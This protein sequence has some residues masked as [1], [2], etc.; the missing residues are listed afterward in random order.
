MTVHFDCTMC[1]KCCHDLKLPLSVD[2]ALVWAEKGHPIKLLVEA[3]PWTGPPAENDGKAIHDYGRTFPEMC[4]DIPIRVAV[5]LV[6]WHQGACPYL[7]PDMRC[8]QYAVRP[9]VCRIYPLMARPF[10]TL[11]PAKRL[12][13]PEAWSADLPVLMINGEATD[14]QSAQTLAD[15]RHAMIADVPRL[16]ALCSLLGWSRAGFANE[17]FAVMTLDPA[18]LAKALRCAGENRA[19]MSGMRNWTYVTNRQSTLAMLQAAD[20]DAQLVSQDDGYLGSFPPER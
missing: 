7:L 18:R 2:E 14:P 10:E 16:R 3:L 17:G 5:L 15:H 6:A 9:R 19:A 1:G 4:G 12:C 13:P 11:E 20:C 8:G